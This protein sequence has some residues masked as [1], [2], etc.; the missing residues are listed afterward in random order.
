MKKEK[1]RLIIAL[2]IMGITILG[3]PVTSFSGGL[4]T[5]VV[6][7]AEV[8]NRAFIY[9]WVY[10][11]MDGHVYKRLYN[12]TLGEYVGDWILVQ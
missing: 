11:V 9:E 1:R 5:I 8:E 10:K 3:T 4:R 7:A 12:A 2:A 6:E